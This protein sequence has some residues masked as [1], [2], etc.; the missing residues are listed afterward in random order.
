MVIRAGGLELVAA[1]D[2]LLAKGLRVGDDL[3]RVGLPCRLRRLKEGGGD[4]GDGIVVRAAL[5]RGEN[6]VV[7]ALLQVLGL[8]VVPAEEDEAGTRTTEGFV[9]ARGSVWGTTH[10]KRRKVLR[11]GGDNV[12]VLEWIRELTGRNQTRC[13]CDVGHEK[14]AVLI[15]SRAQRR[16]V[17]IPRVCRRATDYQTGLED[18]SLRRKAL[19]VN[20]LVGWVEGVWE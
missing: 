11:R 14:R 15:S 19:V 8:L 4:A 13:V 17:P 16:I 2:E 7:D 6:S 1:R 5:A 12:T 20:Q 18:L 3:F 10:A 9:A